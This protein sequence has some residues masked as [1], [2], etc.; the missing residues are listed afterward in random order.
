MPFVGE[1]SQMPWYSQ[2]WDLF[3]FVP[4]TSS[5]HAAGTQYML[6]G[7]WENEQLRGWMGCLAE[8]QVGPARQF[9][10]HRGSFPM[11]GITSSSQAPLTPLKDGALN[12]PPPAHGEGGTQLHSLHRCK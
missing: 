1:H 7:G 8:I 3:S 11:T 9:A 12:S 4:L 10:L 5:V 2:R 6:W